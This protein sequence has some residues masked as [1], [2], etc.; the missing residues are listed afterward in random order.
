MK[1]NADVGEGGRDDEALFRWIGMAN[2]ACGYHAGDLKTMAV[3]VD[4]A[5]TYGVTV[6]AHPGYED[7]EGFG[8]RSVAHLPGEIEQLVRNQ[9]EVL[10]EICQQQGTRVEYVKPHGAL[11][12]DM[13]ERADVYEEIL[14]AIASLPN[15]LALM[16]MARADDERDHL[17]ARKFGVPLIFEAFADRAYTEKGTLL[18]RSEEGAVL[19]SP[20][21]MVEQ[22]LQIKKLST[23]S[24][25]GGTAIPM[26]AD[27]LCVHGDN[28]AAI[29]AVKKLY[30]TLRT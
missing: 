15:H 20:D 8:R 28:E 9:V 6:G 27:T 10:E 23:V 4:L 24:T 17:M 18:R 19:S 22:A 21:A 26:Q 16:M 25:V 1:L 11:Y 12:H 3:T 14:Q 5:V 7:R 13:M 29:A 2:I 30:L